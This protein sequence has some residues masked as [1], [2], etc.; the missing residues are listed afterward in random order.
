MMLLPHIPVG[1]RLKNIVKESKKITDDKWVLSTLKEGLKFDFL[2][3]PPQ[4]GIKQTVVNPQTLPIMIKEVNDLLEKGSIETVPPSEIH[5]GFYSTLFLVPKKT[6]NLRPVTSLKPLNQY[7]RKQHFTMDTLSKVLNLVYPQDWALFLDLKDAYLHVPIHM[8]HRKF[9]RF[10]IQGKLYQF[11][12]LCFGLSQAPRV[13]TKIVTVIAAYLRMQNIRLASYL[14]DW[15]L[16]NLQKEA[17]ISD[18]EKTLHLL[19]KLGFIINLEKSALKPTQEI[20]YIGA[21]FKFKREIVTRTQ[22]RIVKLESA[23]QNIM[24]GQNTARDYLVLLGLIASCIELIPN[25]RLF[26]RPIQLHLLHFWKPS[27]ADLKCRISFTQ[28]LNS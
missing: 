28:H 17:L 19:I 13:F 26:M 4:T 12:A 15:L 5:Q 20:T 3:I 25:A 11:V 27:S 2:L 8:S 16:V 6:E 18:R 14:D 1:G 24:K 23:V 21:L 10:C 22:D 9:L 7:M